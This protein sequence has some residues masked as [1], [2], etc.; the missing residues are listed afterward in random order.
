MLT[1]DE[2]A[3]LERHGGLMDL[4]RSVKLRLSGPDA[5]RYLNGQVTND[6]RRLGRESESLEACLCNHKGKLEAFVHIIRDA[7][8]AFYITAD[9]ALREFLPL[10]LEK[11]LI[12]DDAALEDV[13]EN[14][15]LV[16]GW[17][18]AASRLREGCAS[19]AGA[20]PGIFAANR[21]RSPG[22]DVWLPAKAEAGMDFVSAEALETLRI[23]RGIPAWV[24]E[25]SGDILPP[26]ARL[27]SSAIDYYKGCYTGQEV[28]SRI[29]SVGKVNRILVP[30]AATGGQTLH[31]GWELF[32]RTADG[33]LTSAGR[34][35]SAARHP[36][37]QTG[38]ALG[39]VKRAALEGELLA[40]P[41]DA[42]PSVA[43]TVRKTLDD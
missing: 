20:G 40:G 18:E 5:L 43:L 8:G 38:I 6:V 22:I 30:L 39:F 1:A 2:W 31:A 42:S 14:H 29:R 9:E 7:S 12:A 35:T 33:S 13:S 32:A 36:V 3:Q 27:D 28:I 26:E 19:A 34:I 4:S 23:D 17:G 37:L 21:L 24:P 25:L 16:H 11:Y 15:S 41:G 10:R